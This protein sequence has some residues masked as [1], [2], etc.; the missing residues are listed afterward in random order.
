MLLCRNPCSLIDDTPFHSLFCNYIFTLGILM[1]MFRREPL[2]SASILQSTTCFPACGSMKSTCL[3][4]ETNS[5]LG[6]LS[7]DW[8]ALSSSLCSQIA[9]TTRYLCCI[10]TLGNILLRSNGWKTWANLREKVAFWKRVG[11]AQDCGRLIRGTWMKLYYH[12]LQ[13]LQKQADANTSIWL[14]YVFLFQVNPLWVTLSVHHILSWRRLG[15]TG[16]NFKSF[17]GETGELLGLLRAELSNEDQILVN[18]Y[19]N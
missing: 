4:L 12:L 19:P 7:T 2:S 6:M 5:V 11:E 1:Q 10:H 16:R 17:G 9:S 15:A 13:E 18:P 14:V 3:H 8:E